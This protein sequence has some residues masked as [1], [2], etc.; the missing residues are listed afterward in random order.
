[1]AA[2]PARKPRVGAVVIFTGTA[3]HNGTR[4]YPA[5]VTQVFD[6][7]YI[8]LKVLPPFA[9]IRDEGSVPHQSHESAAGGRFWSWPS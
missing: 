7:P 3:L 8:N 6:G 2:Q 5:I 4:S 9:E 1:M